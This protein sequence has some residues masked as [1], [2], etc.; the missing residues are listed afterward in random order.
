[1]DLPKIL[2]KTIFLLEP[3]IIPAPV[4]LVGFQ[5]LLLWTATAVLI[6]VSGWLI[7]TLVRLKSRTPANPVD[8]SSTFLDT[9]W[10]LIPVAILILIIWLTIQAVFWRGV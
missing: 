1:M 6:V 2:A 10:T 9:I 7:F 5:E 8:R 4:S 3:Q